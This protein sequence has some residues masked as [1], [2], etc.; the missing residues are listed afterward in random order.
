M[1]WNGQDIVVKLEERCRDIE[2]VLLQIANAEQA[3]PDERTG[4]GE[5]QRRKLHEL[6]EQRKCARLAGERIHARET[7]KHIQREIRA[8]ARTRKKTRIGA[9]LE[10]FRGLREIANIRGDKKKNKIGSMR[11]ENGEVMTDRQAIADVFGTF[12]EELYKERVV[13]EGGAMHC[14]PSPSGHAIPEITT[15]EVT[16]QLNKMSR[17][18]AC[19]SNGVVAELLKEGGAALHAILADVFNDIL[20]PEMEVPKYWK[21]TRLKVLFK[22]GDPQLPENYRPIAIIPILYKLFS[23]IVFNRIKTVLTQAQSCDQAGFRPGFSCD[24]NL[25]AIMLLTE[26]MN[27]FNQPLWVVAVDFKKAFDTINHRSLWKAL[28]EQGVPGIYI[29]CLQKLYAG[30]EGYVQSDRNS[31]RFNIERG[32]KQ[33]DPISPSLFNAVLEKQL[34][35]QN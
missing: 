30:Q 34:E 16:R 14:T 13:K 10:E 9:I 22:K 2:H 33:G 35:M 6:I 29:T 18:K 24:D 25:F 26:K 1:E 5:E 11:N 21:E 23:R 32:A 3:R 8:I 27:E 28:Q 31:F 7:S 20:K 19:D 12:Y 17:R 4:E 15:G